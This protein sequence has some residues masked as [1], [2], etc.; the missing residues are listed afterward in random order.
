MVFLA[1]GN[2]RAL[3]SLVFHKTKALPRFSGGRFGDAFLVI[4][5]AILLITVG[6]A[7][8]PVTRKGELALIPES[9]ELEIGQ[10][11]Y[12]PSRQM[13]G[14]DY[15]LDPELAQYVNEVGNRIAA[16]SDRKLPYEFVV[17]N[18]GTPNAWAL[19]GGKIAVNRGLLTELRSEA[20]LA[21]VLAHE[22]VHA[23]ARHGAKG[24]ER[25]LLLQGLML[26][27]AVASGGY[28]FS[29]LAVGSAVVGAN[30]VKQ[31]YSREDELE[32]D[33]YSMIYLA[34]AGYDPVA[35]V[36]LQELF[37]ELSKEKKSNWLEGL[38][39]SHPPSQER[40]EKNRETLAGLTLNEVETGVDRYRAKT[41]HLLA[42]KP[43]YALY[44]KG[45]RALEQSKPSEAVSLATEAIRQEPRE[46][47][48]H[49]LLGEALSLQGDRQGALHAYNAA[50]QKDPGFFRHYLKR[51]QLHEAIKD[52]NL[53]RKDLERSL[54]LF[55]TAE[56]DLSLGRMASLGGEDRKAVDY[57]KE[58]ARSGTEAGKE[59]T[60]LLH[61]LDLPENPDRYLISYLKFK[62]GR[63]HVFISNP[64]AVAISNLSLVLS[65][66]WR[67]KDKVR[68]QTAQ[69]IAANAYTTIPTQIRVAGKQEMREWW[70][71]IEKVK[72]Q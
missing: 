24:V 7:T 45:T 16:V 28:D 58:A 60:Q 50:V 5:S 43:A 59:A 32:A 49:C 15:L 70:L 25:N 39:S 6:C 40:V 72:I 27:V 14:G 55:S 54:E 53:A 64:T 67:E 47:V 42:L 31:T 23:A 61:R 33:H 4:A 10:S 57:L 30:L 26:A 29:A 38:F 12:T 22:I 62:D 34:R 48:F 68:I 71:R 65:K 56:A 20:E 2:F 19:P 13:Q 66:G 9:L 69:K 3:K 46:A 1:G 51:G 35:A 17:L 37:V 11:Q 36:D 18:N 52:T 63:I 41:D 44:E 8:N 21:A